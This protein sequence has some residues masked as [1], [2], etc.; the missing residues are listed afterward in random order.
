[1]VTNAKSSKVSCKE[2][3]CKSLW[4]CLVRVFVFCFG[5]VTFY[6]IKVGT[7]ILI[8]IQDCKKNSV[9]YI[10]LVL[11]LKSQ[12]KKKKNVWYIVLVF[13][14]NFYHY[15]INFFFFFLSFFSPPPTYYL[16]IS[17][18]FPFFSPP[19]TYYLTVRPPPQTQLRPRH[20]P[21]PK[22][23]PLLHHFLKPY[24]SLS[25]TLGNGGSTGNYA[26]HRQRRKRRRM[27][28]RGRVLRE[29]WS[30]QV[31]G[32]HRSRTLPPQTPWSLLVL[33]TCRSV[34]G[35][36]AHS[37][38]PVNLDR[39][40]SL[41]FFFFFLILFGTWKSQFCLGYWKSFLLE[42]WV[43]VPIAQ[44]L[45]DQMQISVKRREKAVAQ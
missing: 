38:T 21:P 31:H 42:I 41:E 28:R 26:H 30:S 45:K 17:F 11:Q 27:Q 43:L 20:P 3:K 36:E 19:P 8:W 32:P 14:L 25:V 5:F 12:F 4:A 16:F 15:I 22:H 10:V 34:R 13:K 39:P 40:I 2:K 6:F 33:L 9:W 29:D 1:M 37:T 35:P 7:L 44:N 23:T 24:L 18:F